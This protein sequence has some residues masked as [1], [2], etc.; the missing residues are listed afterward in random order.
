MT[1]D[2]LF[3]QMTPELQR[4]YEQFYSKMFDSGLPFELNE[5]LRLPIVQKAYYAQNREPLDVVNELRKEAGLDPITSEENEYKVTWTLK[6][7]HFPGADG[8][9]RAFDIRLLKYGKP[10]WDTKWDG[11]KNSIP[12]YLEAAR[13]GQSVGL[14]AGGF[15]EKPDFPHFELRS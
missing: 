2:Q 1:Q 4:L 8:L 13:I 15:W 6:S 10:H 14:V 7:H 11:N 12:D 3:K 5:V 9:S